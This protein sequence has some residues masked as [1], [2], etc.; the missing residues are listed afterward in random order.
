MRRT[1]GR[2]G[3]R[4]VGRPST[5][6]S[7]LGSGQAGGVRRLA[8]L[9]PEPVCKEVVEVVLA[10]APP[11]GARFEFKAVSLQAIVCSSPLLISQHLSSR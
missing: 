6:D 10:G 11:L 2:S 1:G 7:A 9:P 5:Q 4:Q 8:P 3:H